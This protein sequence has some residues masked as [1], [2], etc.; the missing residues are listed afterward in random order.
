MRHGTVPTD[1]MRPP[2]ST[3]SKNKNDRIAQKHGKCARAPRRKARK[4]Q[5]KEKTR[6]LTR[7]PAPGRS[8]MMGRQVSAGAMESE[9]PARQPLPGESSQR[10]L[11][12][13]FIRAPPM[14]GKAASEGSRVPYCIPPGGSVPSREVLP[15]LAL[16]P[17]KDARAVGPGESLPDEGDLLCGTDEKK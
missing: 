12:P 7:E 13:Q 10:S 5:V 4:A 11:L 17:C 2:H 3:R 6:E 9:I 16:S 8:Q 15:R 14:K 1:A